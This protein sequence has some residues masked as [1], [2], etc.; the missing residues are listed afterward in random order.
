VLGNALTDVCDI[1]GR[2]VWW[3]KLDRP[4]EDCEK[5]GRQTNHIHDFSQGQCTCGERN[6]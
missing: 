1:Q 3:S 2:C 4:C 5:R 6:N